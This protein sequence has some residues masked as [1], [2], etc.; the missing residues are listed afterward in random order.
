MRVAKKNK[1]R[2]PKGSGSLFQRKRDGKWVARVYV[3]KGLDGM[4]VK[5]FTSSTRDGALEKLQRAKDRGLLRRER[6]SSR[7]ISDFAKAW[8]ASR[9]LDGRYKPTTIEWQRQDLDFKIIPALGTIPL[10]D[11][12]TRDVARFI[13][14]LLAK[15][16]GRASVD[17]ATRCL[18]AMLRAAVSAEEIETNPVSRLSPAQRAGYK[19]PEAKTLTLEQL[20][21]LFKELSGRYACAVFV[22][23]MT[24]L[25]EGEILGLEWT[26]ID[27]KC[28]RI[29]VRRNIVQIGNV[30]HELEPKT[31]SSKRSVPIPK[32]LATRLFKLRGEQRRKGM[33]IENGRLFLTDS[34][35]PPERAYLLRKVLRPALK[36]A[37]LPSISWRELRHS[38]ASASIELGVPAEALS[39]SLGHKN[40]NVTHGI[41]NKAFRARETL[42][43]DLWDAAQKRPKSVK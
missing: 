7:P 12:R 41:Y 31:E 27:F 22:A 18:S 8:H 13:A 34:G 23:G 6:W 4:S 10:K 36:R 25:R 16:T 9:I 14:D 39:R 42:V 43:A 38:F 40:V 1:K 19:A 17:R 26:D 32:A 21:S 30:F 2:R 15:K 11:L 33:D 24:G 37:A 29:N 28:L 3:Q 20:Q 35:R 5:E